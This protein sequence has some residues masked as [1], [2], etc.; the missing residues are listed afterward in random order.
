MDELCR[1]ARKLVPPR[2][3]EWKEGGGQ[4]VG[5]TC[6]ATPREIFDAAGILPYRL[7]A[8]GKPERDHADAY[9]SRFNC[10]FC[11]ACLQLALE[12]A[13][14]FLDG[15]VETNGCDHLRGM[16]ENWSRTTNPGFFH[17]LKVPHLVTE[18]SL[19]FFAEELELLRE[20]LANYFQ[21]D[22]GDSALSEA[23]RAANRRRE[24]MRELFS[25]R[26]RENPA[27]T[28]KEALAALL[29]ESSLPPAA[30]DAL[31]EQ[32]LEE[33][34]G[35]EIRGYRA[36]L[37]LAGSATDEPEL[38]GEIEDLGGL[39]VTDALCYGTRT[40]WKLPEVEGEPIPALA[41]AYLRHLLCPRMFDDYPSR[42]E[43]ILRAAERARV[44]GAVLVYN[45]FCDLH[46]VEN[47]RLR[48]DLEERG[49]PVLV[50]EKEYGSPADLGRIRTRV[51]A[52]LERIS[53]RRGS[54]VAALPTGGV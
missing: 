34:Q 51:Q 30:F 24:R 37:L 32:L 49:I 23:V 47:V 42:L 52:F 12:G 39:V 25:L 19:E 50:L 35:R 3:R 41:E 38:V 21:V 33:V 13:Y 43:F 10:G 31:L 17:Y 5:Y 48:L 15:L 6:V 28:G 40:F 7:R 22:I 16:F 1:M 18:E 4:V 26:E 44:D 8:L 54:G 2:L 29:L 11:R 46:G 45:K 27:L 20:S 36:R 53:G 14:D 9:L